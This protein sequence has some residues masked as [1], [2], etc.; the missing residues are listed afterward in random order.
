VVWHAAMGFK[1]IAGR[2]LASKPVVYV[3]KISYG[4]YILHAFVPGLLSRV[5]PGLPGF[6]QQFGV[7]FWLNVLTT[8]GL[9]SLSWFLLERPANRLKS[10]FRY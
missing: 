8:I 7:W 4:I 3:G 6:A 2:F 10:R 1:G 9:A 5:H